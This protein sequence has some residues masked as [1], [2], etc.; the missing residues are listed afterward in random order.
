VTPFR[1]AV[2]YQR[3]G[4]SCLSPSLY[5]SYSLLLH[6][7]LPGTIHFT[8]KTEARRSSETLVSHRNIARRHNLEDRDLNLHRCENLKFRGWERFCVRRIRKNME[9]IGYGLCEGT[10]PAFTW[11]NWKKKSRTLVTTATFRVENQT[12]N[13]SN[14]R[15]GT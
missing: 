14:T 9:V 11:R 13:L 15:Q 10:I 12:R 1:V 6:L 5:P 8:L 7:L 3:F 2:G 4:G